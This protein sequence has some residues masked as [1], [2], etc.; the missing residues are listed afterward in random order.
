MKSI[1]TEADLS[2]VKEAVSNAEKQTS[3]EIVPY[4]VQKS[5]GHEVAV[6]RGAGLFA[7]LAYAVVLGIRWFSGWGGTQLTEGITPVLLIIG[8]GGIGAIMVHWIPTAKRYFAGQNRL[9]LA[10]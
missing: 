4:I 10:T 9:A 3:G 2:R 5:A 6:W 8:I 1:M 7:L